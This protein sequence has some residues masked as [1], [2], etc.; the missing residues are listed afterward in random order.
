MYVKRNLDHS[1]PTQ[2]ANMC[3]SSSQYDVRGSYRSHPGKRVGLSR[4]VLG[5]FA[6]CRETHG[7]MEIWRYLPEHGMGHVCV[8]ATALACERRYALGSIA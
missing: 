2:R 4:L 8:D 1:D 7:G 5:C 3:A 6:T